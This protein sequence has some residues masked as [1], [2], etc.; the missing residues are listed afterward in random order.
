MAKAKPKRRKTLVGKTDLQLRRLVATE[1]N[2][3][4]GLRKKLRDA[5]R[6]KDEAVAEASKANTDA[7]AARQD[8]EELKGELY[9]LSRKPS[10]NSG[11]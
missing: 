4:K 10:K 2:I 7:A 6:E 5:Q 9:V 1:R 3:S 11:K 8:L